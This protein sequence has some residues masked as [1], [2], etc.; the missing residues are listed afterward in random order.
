MIDSHVHLDHIVKEHPHRISWMEKN[1]CVPVS[2]A[3]GLHIEDREGLRG[4]LKRHAELIRNLNRDG[5]G[6]YYLSGIH[7]R[8]I[9][10]DL[11]A[12][13][14]E[15]LEQIVA[16][17][18]HHLDRIMCNTDSGKE[19][20]EDLCDFYNSNGFPPAL[21]ERLAYRNANDFFMKSG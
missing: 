6:C 5:L 9:S 12:E 17:F 4:Y 16:C 7:P 20:Y 19:F 21:R 14:V 11:R 10:P 18:P 8:N 15:E 13:D 1:R 3:F 2:W